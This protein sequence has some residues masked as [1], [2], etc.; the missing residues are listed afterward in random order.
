MNC[1]LTRG[2]TWYVDLLGIKGHVTKI[3]KTN[4]SRKKGL[5]LAFVGDM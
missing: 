3:T 2:D 5:A 1:L 4:F